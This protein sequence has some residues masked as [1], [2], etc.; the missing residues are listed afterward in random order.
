MRI[1]VLVTLYALSCAICSAQA[2]KQ[3]D[4]QLRHIQHSIKSINLINGLNLNVDQMV[5]LKE[6]ARQANTLEKA[7]LSEARRAEGSALAV[8]Q[9]FYEQLKENRVPGDMTKHMVHRVEHPFK[10][11]QANYNEQMADKVKEA[12]GLLNPGQLAMVKNYRPCI[13]PTVDLTDPSRIGSAA[14]ERLMERFTQIR[15]LSPEVYTRR[16]QNIIDHHV[17]RMRLHFQGKID[18]NKEAADFSQFLE[19]VRAMDDVDWQLQGAQ[20]IEESKEAKELAHRPHIRS[21]DKTDDFIRMFL[22]NPSMYE[23]YEERINAGG[24]PEQKLPEETKKGPWQYHGWRR[25]HN[26]R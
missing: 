12:K 11:V 8:L 18:Q 26:R 16:K 14:S 24:A 13:V 25:F 20:L 6:L 10:A 1:L 21:R 23:I 2:L 15:N 5:G 4:P 22:L 9:K 17:R 3:V 7:A 19:K